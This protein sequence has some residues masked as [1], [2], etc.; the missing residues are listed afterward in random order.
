MMALLLS[1]LFPIAEKQL[2]ALALILGGRW[3]A[4]GCSRKISI[5]ID[6]KGW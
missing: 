3:I 4:G 5:H 2:L 1:A 6:E